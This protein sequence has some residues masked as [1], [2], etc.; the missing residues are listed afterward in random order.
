MLR[1]TCVRM[2]SIFFLLA[3]CLP[4][5][6]ARAQST[7]WLIT[8]STPLANMP[9]PNLPIA[10]GANSLAA[11]PYAVSSGDNSSGFGY[12]AV[13]SGANAS[14][15]GS[16]SVASG[17]NSVAVGMLSRATGPNTTA[18]GNSSNASGNAST[19]IGLSSA[20]SALNTTAIGSQATAS[21]VNS[22]ALGN[23]SVANAANTVSFG[24]AGGE[25]RLT[26]LAAGINPTDGVNVAQLTAL[27][28]SVDTRISNA[29][30]TFANWQGTGGVSSVAVGDQAIASGVGTI[31]I[32][33][34]AAATGTNSIALGTGAAANNAVAV[35]TGAL[36]TNNG[37]AFGNLSSATG[38]NST[39]LGPNASAT[40]PDSTAIGSGSVA[41]QAN[42]V[43]V[44]TATN[45]RRI[46]NVAAGVAPGD[47]VNMQQLQGGLSSLGSRIDATNARIDTVDQQAK[48]GIAAT[49]ALAPTIMPSKNGKT[50]VSLST[51][52]YRG[53]MAL[54]VGMAHRLDVS[55][56]TVLFGSYA[57]SGGVEHVARVGVA[58][59]F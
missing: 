55:A 18:V 47:A 3:A 50:T 41:D 16:T 44:G 57:N 45:Q 54:S 33:Q 20:A 31:G 46:T 17:T 29:F 27:D 59:E 1:F 58:T 13:A 28:I 51:G 4:S 19:A 42:T 10:S 56:P 7:E 8:S 43:S 23:G 15:F 36:A 53:E 21:G 12:S 25:R 24:T 6:P 49:A 2:A 5:G 32:G 35:G 37:A 39:A 14:A 30:N 34:N 48:R 40:A 22:V 11:G 38:A 52:F 26:N 9:P